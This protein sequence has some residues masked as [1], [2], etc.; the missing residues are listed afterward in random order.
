MQELQ[1]ENIT[2]APLDLVIIGLY[3]VFILAAGI[4]VSRM[5]SKDIDSYFLGSRRMHGGCS[6]FREPHVISTWRA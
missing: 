2:V 6:V 4:V 5:A 3:V 1:V